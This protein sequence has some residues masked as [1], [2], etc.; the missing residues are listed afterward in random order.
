MC[1]HTHYLINAGESQPFGSIMARSLVVV[2]VLLFFFCQVVMVRLVGAPNQMTAEDLESPELV[3]LVK[4]GLEKE[5]SCLKLVQIVSGTSQIISGV[6]YVLQ[7][8]TTQDGCPYIYGD[9]GFSD[10]GNHEITIIKW[11][12]PDSEPTFSIS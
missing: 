11:A 6:K 7:L 1:V 3:E 10:S 4:Q 2:S 9:E 12:D 5:N 8:K